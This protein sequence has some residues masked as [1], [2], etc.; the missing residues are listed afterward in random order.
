MRPGIHHLSHEGSH[1]C[2]HSC[3]SFGGLHPRTVLSSAVGAL[4]LVKNQQPTTISNDNSVNNTNYINVFLNDKCRNACDI[5]R[6]IAG[7]DF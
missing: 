5:R 3:S 4:E 2:S 7:I 1:S 6:F